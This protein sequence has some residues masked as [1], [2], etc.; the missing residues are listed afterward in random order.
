MSTIFM[1]A[2]I[3]DGRVLAARIRKKIKTRIVLLPTVPGLAVILV[4]N[5]PAS[6]TYV[7]IKQ[8]ACEEVG[9]RFEKYLYFA[10]EPE[11]TIIEKIHELNAR[12]DIH[13]ILVQ[14]PL[15]TQN[16]DLVIKEIDPKKDVDGFHPEN[17]RRLKAG[18]PAIA[19][20]VALGIIKLIEESK[21][22][23]DF[24]R[25][26]R[27]VII[28]GPLFAEPLVCLLK[29]RNIETT[30]AN[31]IDPELAQKTKTADVLIVAVGKPGIITGEMIKPGAIVIDV[32]TTKIDG[33]LYGDVDQ[34]SVEPIAGALTPVP[35]G[36]GPMT[37]AMLLNNVLNAY[38]LQTDPS[39]R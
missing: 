23:H 1:T 11:Q 15:P 36:V 6:H 10:T 31:A 18:E 20:A 14:L 25:G 35:G 9:I 28:S 19:S 39:T 24:S 26:S 13:G 33:K 30:V 5:D 32:G 38:Q 7:N 22:I 17:L 27:T 16:A 29:E 4:G 8:A 34:P 3:L 12:L 2:Q 37:V 21:T